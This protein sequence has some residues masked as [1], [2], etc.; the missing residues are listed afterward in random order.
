[1]FRAASCRATNKNLPPKENRRSYHKTPELNYL[2]RTTFQILR[3]KTIF[4][5][6][7]DLEYVALSRAVQH[8]HV[9]FIALSASFETNLLKSNSVWQERNHRLQREFNWLW[10][11]SFKCTK[12]SHFLERC[13]TIQICMISELN[14]SFLGHG[15]REVTTLTESQIAQ[16]NSDTQFRCQNQRGYRSIKT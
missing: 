1:M 7:A 15:N 12:S 9:P 3:R 14:F 6:T 13:T 11:Y 8:N 4:K 2:H 10:N 16:L 5:R